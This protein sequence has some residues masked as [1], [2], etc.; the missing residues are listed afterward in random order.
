MYVNILKLNLLLC[1]IVFSASCDQQKKST[2]LAYKENLS[3]K[4]TTT[5][6]Q[7]AQYIRHIFQDKNG[8]FWLGTNS[9]GV[10]YVDGDSLSYFSMEQGFSGY[11][12][13]GISEDPEKNL[14]FATDQGVVKYDW[15]LT[16]KG[17]KQFTNY[18]KNEFF[19]GKGC[20]SI[21]ADSKGIIWA[22]T[23]KGV[24]RFE[25]EQWTLFELPYAKD[26][27]ADNLLTEVTIWGIMEDAKGN[28]WFSTNGNG[29]IQYNGHSYIQ[30]L[31]KDGLADDNVDPIIE[32]RQGNI[33]LGTRFGGLS[34]FDGHTFTNYSQQ[35][36]MIGNDEVCIVYEDSYGNIWFSSE[37]FGVYRYDGKSLT[38]FFK[39]QGL[40]VKAIQAI[41]EDRDGRLWVGGGGGLYR[42]D[43]AIFSNVTKNGPW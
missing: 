5:N 34:K 43:G 3:T 27:R 29:A 42:F 32:D 8:H 22:G 39:P 1:L 28:I 15:S 25:Y 2:N 16:K 10:A 7:I 6:P 9:Y 41:Y 37:G 23:G 36:H 21:F 11:Q 30:Y 26:D 4:I 24:F 17:K 38:N 19:N 40:H 20:W 31:K 18:L 13:T 14:W 12:I 33:W 35:N